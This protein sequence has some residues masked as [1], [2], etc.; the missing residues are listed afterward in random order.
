MTE[1]DIEDIVFTMLMR[2]SWMEAKLSRFV[3]IPSRISSQTYTTLHQLILLKTA[4]PN[5]IE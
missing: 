3:P 1:L 5:E 2:L 4:I